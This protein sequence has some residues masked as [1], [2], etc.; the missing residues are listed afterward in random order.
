ME[1]IFYS[2]F[3]VIFLLFISPFAKKEINKNKHLEENDYFKE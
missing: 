2:F 1:L 3:V